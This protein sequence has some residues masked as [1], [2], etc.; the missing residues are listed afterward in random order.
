MT[1]AAPIALAWLALAIPI[2]IFYI[3][4]IRLRR[5]P[6]ATTIFWRQ[7][8]DE[9]QPRSIWQHLRHLLSL[10]VQIT[11]LLLLVFAL[12]QPLFDWELD[13]S[14]RVVL[15]LDNSAS[16]R[17]V[18][19]TGERFEQAKEI[20]HQLV[21][22]LRFRDEMAI[23][24]AGAE[25]Q[26]VCGMTG[27][28]RTLADAVDAIGLS[29]GPTRVTEAVELGRRL[30][31]DSESGSVVVVSDGAFANATELASADDVEL[32]RVGQSIS[33]VGI[34][35]LQVRR[36]LLDPLGYEILLEVRNASEEEVECR[37]EVDLND[38][39][40]DVLP[41]T[42]APGQVWSQTIEK[43]SADGGRLVARINRDD[44]LA[45]DN[46]AWALLPKREPQ[47]VVLV[48]EGNLFLQKVLEA[49]PLV[50]LTVVK[51]L[52][53]A[54]P[55]DALLVFHRAVP[56]Q[57]PAGNVLVVDPV[58][59]TDAWELGETLANPV[60]TKQDQDSPLLR[61]VRLDNVLLPEARKLTLKDGAQ[62][63]V[64]ALSG[65]PLYASIKRASGKLLVLTVNIDQ[66]DL[67]FRTAFP[68]MV[69]NALGWFAGQSGELRESLAAGAVAEVHFPASAKAGDRL[70]LVSPS[71][72]QR[73]LPPSVEKAN[74]GPLDECG[75][76]SIRRAAANEQA[77]ESQS[78]S[79]ALVELA[80]NLSN[81]AESE[82]RAA[83]ATTAP[84]YLAAGF[85]GG[86]MTRPFWFYLIVAAWL[87]A[88]VE[89]YLYQRRWIT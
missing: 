27:H 26:V 17:A 34:T 18:D 63:L 42:L 70:F 39:P 33:N 89:W 40:I 83:D 80:C 9:K 65:D 15:V 1:F 24:V 48:T 22:R 66:G 43:T 23:V 16:M 3:L 14:R 81:R 28:E 19:D 32:H 62:N 5:V 57:L 54:Y 71:G 47:K 60:V 29:D 30:I 25:P 53:K 58:G 21:R 64:T 84:D 85:A 8:F 77:G 72:V 38:Q 20:A 4:K 10:L 11:L 52:P 76:W 73:P 41:L 86:W 49:N 78:A 31:G 59:A 46:T 50:Q 36:S 51:E 79:P 69:T 87:L 55:R 44:A 61:H 74:I 35:N 13:Q 82:L 75:V 2:V 67:A 12:A 56:A 88:A 45:T 37:L 7:I 68:I 6:V